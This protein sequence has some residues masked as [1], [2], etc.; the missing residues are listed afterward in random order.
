MKRCPKCNRA[1]SDDSLAFCRADGTRLLSDSGFVSES[2]GTL[3][4]GSAPVTGEAGTRILPQQGATTDE[5][6]SRDTAPTTMLDR[7]RLGGGT[8][9][10]GEPKSRRV[11]VILAALIA[12]ALTA[13]A[14]LYLSRGKGAAAKNSIAVLPFVNASGDPNMEY[15]SD[16]ISENIINS[17]SQLSNVRV[18]ARTTMFSFKGKDADPRAVGRQMGVDAVLTGRVVQR[19]DT[20]SIQADLLNVSDGSQTWGEQYNRKLTDLV[21]LQG[22]IARDVSNKLRLKLSGADEQKLTKT[23]TANPE[24]HQLYLKGLFYRNKF[25]LIYTETSVRHF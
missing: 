14:Y 2:A 24:A 12:V 20:L 25:N 15:L 17:L 22:E 4:L 9:Q 13:S 16:G 1:E 11:V 23:Y 7:Q 19:G 5:A 3:K 18:V 10:L 6:L 8:Q 21:A